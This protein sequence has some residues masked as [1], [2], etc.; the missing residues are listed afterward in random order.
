MCSDLLSS[1]QKNQIGASVV[2][3]VNRSSAPLQSISG[4]S[5][6]FPFHPSCPSG[7][8]PATAG[9]AVVGTKNV[10]TADQGATPDD[11]QLFL[12]SCFSLDSVYIRSR[13]SLLFLKTVAPAW[14]GRQHTEYST[15]CVA[16]HLYRQT[17]LAHCLR[18]QSSP[19]SCDGSAS[20]ITSMKSHLHCTC[21][22]RQRS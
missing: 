4:Q 20:R 5:S 22:R 8:Y 1:D 21:S 6:P 18:N 14:T 10:V 13:P 17:W 15:G 12:S 3:V 7:R 19:L 11:L 9:K 2:L 16:S